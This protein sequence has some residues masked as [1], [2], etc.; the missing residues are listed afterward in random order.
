VA[1]LLRREE[2]ELLILADSTGKEQSVPKAKVERRAVS[3][4]S[5]MP[6]NFSELIPPRDLSD[7]VAF[8]VAN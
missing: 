3:P 2:G 7:L 6:S 1:G 5:P 4:L 8:L